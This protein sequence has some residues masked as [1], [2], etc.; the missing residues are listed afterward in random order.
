MYPDPFDLAR[1]E[2]AQNNGVY[3]SSVK[4]LKA[5]LKTSHWM[6]FIFPQL[7]GLGHS[8]YADFYG[9]KGI[10]EAKAYLAFSPIGAR[11][12]NCTKLINSLQNRTAIEIFGHDDAVKL[13]SCMTLFAQVSS[14]NSVFHQ[15]IEKYFNGVPDKLTLNLL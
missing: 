11:L 13:R 3:E 10:N 6:W 5:G 14:E 4:E 1:F 12:L 8:Y 15:A 9:L 7:K 2:H